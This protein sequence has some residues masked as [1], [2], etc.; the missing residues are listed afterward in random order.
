ML[1]PLTA[2][3]TIIS[4]LLISAFFIG[5]QI[6]QY[7]SN[8]LR[9][10]SGVWKGSD[11]VTVNGHQIETEATLIIEPENSHLSVNQTYEN[12]NYT[13]DA[14]VRPRRVNHES[15]HIELYNRSVHGLDNFIEATNISVPTQANLLSVNI[16]RLEEGKLFLQTRLNGIEEP[17][18]MILKIK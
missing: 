12:V 18:E 14:N 7:Q 6:Y 15:T 11:F 1:Q 5:N 3:I 13:L 9:L 10:Y 4:C 17:V 8:P 2:R 16:W